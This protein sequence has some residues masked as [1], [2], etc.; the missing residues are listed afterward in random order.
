MTADE[1]SDKDSISNEKTSVRVHLPTYDMYLILSIV[2]PSGE[3]K[4]A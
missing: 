2:F 1:D 3:I 4:H